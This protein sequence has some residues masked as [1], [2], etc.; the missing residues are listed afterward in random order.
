MARRLS[1]LALGLTAVA[2]ST[3]GAMLSQSASAATPAGPGLDATRNQSINTGATFNNSYGTSFEATG[4]LGG[5]AAFTA[6]GTA[7]GNLNSGSAYV[8]A[9]AAFNGGSAGQVTGVA[10]VTSALLGTG[11]QPINLTDGT[12]TT[13]AATETL[14]RVNAAGLTISG[15]GSSSTVGGS[16]I[17]TNLGVE[18]L[19]LGGSMSE[20][21]TNTLS[22]F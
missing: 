3:A 13:G 2:A 14:A 10:G 12:I 15:A 21:I 1:P 6:P 17:G 16:V 4:D 7:A 20:V 5:T 18:A 8:S 19:T 9:R 11:T 22:A